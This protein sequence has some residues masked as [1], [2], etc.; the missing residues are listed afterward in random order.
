VL[1]EY[2][3][4][5]TVFDH[6]DG[7][8]SATTSTDCTGNT[9]NEKLFYPFGELWTGAAIP[10]LG[11]HQTFAQ[12]PDYDA[13]TDQYNTPARHYSPSGRWMSPDWSASPE[14]V[15]YASLQN[16]QSLNLYAYVLNNPTTATDPT[17]HWCVW[18]FGTSCEE[19]PKIDPNLPAP[20]PPP[21]PDPA[22]VRTDP[23]LNPT[24]S[25]PSTTSSPSDQ[26]QAPMESRGQGGQGKGERGQTSK[27]DNPTKGAKPI[28]DKD[29]KITGWKLPT[30]DGKGKDKSLDWGRANGLDP[31]T[32]Q[33]A[34]KVGVIGAV[35]AAGAY[36]ISTFPEWGWGL[37]AV[38]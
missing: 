8:G 20:P 18:G 34:A 33:T 35:G 10:N 16:P 19:H 14:A 3:C 30:P 22:G 28:R 4:G 37:L 5:G 6:P 24:S 11:A 12:L 27:P 13:E 1:A 17:G 36:A 25:N 38:P 2:Y 26:T 9:V 15:P 21:P 31:S 23:D 32:F 7:I 29:G